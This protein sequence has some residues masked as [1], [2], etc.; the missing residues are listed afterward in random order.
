MTSTTKYLT[1]T[2]ID[3]SYLIQKIP[4]LSLFFI[5]FQTLPFSKLILWTLFASMSLL[6]QGAQCSPVIYVEADGGDDG[7]RYY[8]VGDHGSPAEQAHPCSP[9][10]F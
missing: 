6:F 9:F 2:Q 1:N 4:R 5:N 7:G 8:W 3:I 10:V